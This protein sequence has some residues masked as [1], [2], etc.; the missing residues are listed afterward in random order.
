LEAELHHQSV[1][2]PET[3]RIQFED[4]NCAVNHRKTE[5]EQT[6]HKFYTYIAQLYEVAFLADADFS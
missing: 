5:E 1:L 3:Q 6:L 4:S 2:L